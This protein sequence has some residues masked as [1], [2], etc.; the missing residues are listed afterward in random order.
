MACR[1]SIAAIRRFSR[2]RRRS[3]AEP[4][5]LPGW[6]R[7]AALSAT[8]LSERDKFGAVMAV[9]HYARGAAAL[10]IEASDMP[11]WPIPAC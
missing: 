1:T 6:M 7:I 10:A 4:G 8:T 2:Q 11:T 5:Q 9:L 3:A